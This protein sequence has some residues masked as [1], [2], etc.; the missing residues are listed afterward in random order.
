MEEIQESPV[1][2]G[3]LNLDIN[4]T[5]IEA[6]IEVCLLTATE[7]I[8]LEQLSRVFDNGINNEILINIIDKL[9]SRYNSSGLEL[10][11]LASGYRFRS[12][13]EF[14]PYLNKLYQIKP[15]RYSRAIMET[16]AIIAYRQPVTRGEIE[17]IRG[18][19]V[20]SAAIQT[21]LDRGWVEVI[22]QKQVPGR[23]DLLATTTKFLEEF[24]IN[25]LQDLPPLPYI[26][27]SQFT[28]KDDLIEEYDNAKDQVIRNLA[29]DK[30]I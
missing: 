12:K 23:P 7:P 3:N 6:V 10:L 18:V 24:G 11:N 26:D 13:L 21:I 14:Q 2:N 19:S 27:T 4:L 1:I 16:L 15:P 30:I 5:H 20:N 28:A 22:G 9:K 29:E 17:E 25:S 8:S